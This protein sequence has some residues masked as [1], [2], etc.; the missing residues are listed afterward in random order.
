[1]GALALQGIEDFFDAVSHDKCRLSLASTF[2][3]T[4]TSRGGRRRRFFAHPPVYTPEL[5]MSKIGMFRKT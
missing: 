2:H 3:Y 4:A 5:T 1:M